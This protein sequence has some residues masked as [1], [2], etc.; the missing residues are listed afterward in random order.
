[1]SAP[2]LTEAYKSGALSPPDVLEETLER[3]KRYNPE[4]NAIVTPTIEMAA[5]AAQS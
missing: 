2:E 4:L 3:V 5:L 1:M